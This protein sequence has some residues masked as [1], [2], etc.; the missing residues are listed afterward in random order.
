MTK[1][2]QS[3]LAFFVLSTVLICVGCKKDNAQTDP[4]KDP[5][6]LYG[7]SNTEYTG[8]ANV[9]NHYYARPLSLRIS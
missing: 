9:G 3:I 5:T 8:L 6:G 7:F 4:D 1:T 2:T